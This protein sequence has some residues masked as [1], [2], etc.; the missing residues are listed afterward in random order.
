LKDEKTLKNE[1]NGFKYLVRQKS[2]D[3]IKEEDD[4]KRPLKA[5]IE[6]GRTRQCT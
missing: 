2:C 4:S 1:R 3:T 5:E 6:K